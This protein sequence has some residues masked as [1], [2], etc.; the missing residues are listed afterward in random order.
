MRTIINKK[1]AV[2]GGS[3]FIG[4]SL[5][6][7]LLNENS[8]IILFTRKKNYQKT[9]KKIFPDSDIKCIQWNIDNLKTI[10]ENDFVFPKTVF[11]LFR[12]HF[13]LLLL[14]LKIQKK[15]YMSQV[16]SF[17]KS[18]FSCCLDLRFLLPSMDPNFTSSYHDN[19]VCA[20]ELW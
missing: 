17:F 10:E 5:L 11:K 7:L 6:K 18:I 13:T 2:I 1:I 4:R 16:I 20:G 3:G 19:G 9:L 15:M 8:E 14:P 12:F